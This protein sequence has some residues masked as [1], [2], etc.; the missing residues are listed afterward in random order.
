LHLAINFE[1]GFYIG[2][3]VVI[4]NVEIVKVSYRVPKKIST[5]STKLNR[6]FFGTGPPSRSL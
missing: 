3:V 5:A 6:V 1:D 2:E 4:M